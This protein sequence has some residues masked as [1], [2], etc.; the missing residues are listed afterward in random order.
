MEIVRLYHFDR[1]DKGPDMTAS[2]AESRF[3]GEPAGIASAARVAKAD[4]HANEH[5]LATHIGNQA[6]V[7]RLQVMGC[8]CGHLSAWHEAGLLPP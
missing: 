3:L 7:A 4:E 1:R 8:L 2:V 6:C 5:S